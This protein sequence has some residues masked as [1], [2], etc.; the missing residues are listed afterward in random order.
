MPRKR[1]TTPDVN[2]PEIPPMPDPFAPV[3]MHLGERVFMIAPIKER[4][5]DT[6][7]DDS[8][9]FTILA[10][11]LVRRM[12]EMSMTAQAPSVDPN[13][14]DADK[15]GDVLLG[16]S[17]SN[18]EGFIR[19]MQTRLPKLAVY[20]CKASDPAITAQDIK[21]LAKGPLDPELFNL[22]IRQ[23]IA[24]GILGGMGNVAAAV[25]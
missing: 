12:I 10:L 13:A 11:P 5:S 20:A 4:R 17:E 16:L 23:V 25:A 22:V 18:M 3:E 1:I 2:A 19:D 21:N 6:S 14:S 24:E 8:A 9:E 7:F 15:L